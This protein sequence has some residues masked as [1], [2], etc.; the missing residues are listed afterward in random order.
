MTSLHDILTSLLG[1]L[2]VLG[3]ALHAVG[4]WRQYGHETTE[5]VWSLGAAL[6]AVVIGCVNLLLIHRATDAS[7]ALL[8]TASALGWAAVARAYG[9]A[10]KNPYDLRVLWHLGCGAGLAFLSAITLMVALL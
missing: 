9:R 4:T 6:A 3:A 1:A 8:A 10:I 7:L 5:F 2:L